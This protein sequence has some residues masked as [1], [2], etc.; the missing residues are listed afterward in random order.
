MLSA[1]AAIQA[2][3]NQRSLPPLRNPLQVT[4][5]ASNRT[6]TGFPP[7]WERQAASASRM[8]PMG[9]ICEFAQVRFADSG[10]NAGERGQTNAENKLF[11]GGVPAGCG[12][13]ELRSLFS[14]YGDVQDVYILASKAPGWR[15]RASP[16]PARALVGRSS[17]SSLAQQE[18][19][20]GCAFVRFASPQ[21]CAVAIEALHGK[22]AMKAGELPLVV[23]YADP[24]KSQR[25]GG[26]ST[27][28]SRFPWP[29]AP[30]MWSTGPPPPGW[31]LS[32][33]L[34][35][36]GM[37][38]YAPWMGIPGV[39]QPAGGT[40]NYYPPQQQHHLQEQPPPQQQQQPPPPAAAAAAAAAAAQQQQQQQGASMVPA[41]DMATA[42][43]TPPLPSSSPA[44]S[45]WSEHHTPEGLK[46]YYNNSTGTS[47]WECPPE[48]RPAS[49]AAQAA[50]QQPAQQPTPSQASTSVAPAASLAPAMAAL[51][52]SS[53]PYSSDTPLMAQSIMP[54]A[55]A[56]GT[57]PGIGGNG[58]PPLADALSGLSTQ[59]SALRPTPAASSHWM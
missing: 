9:G 37:T 5:A 7:R 33:G 59:L 43:A 4:R 56:L 21:S 53:A 57:L 42:T 3:H 16:R 27:S 45:N 58:Q 28:T 11:V 17:P 20:R 51:S 15:A 40:P 12:D 36:M 34:G 35:G 23:R 49:A 55:S 38:P 29:G 46:Y 48:L 22:Y 39:A 52:M 14:N 44:S 31:P 19:Q 54:D 41:V 8:F 10:T 50:P 18:G 1:Q 47:S 32:W 2:L 30:P 24:P 25:G 13:K 6:S 26:L